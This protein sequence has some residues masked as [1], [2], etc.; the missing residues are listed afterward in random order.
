MPLAGWDWKEEVSCEA[1]VKPSFLQ[2]PKRNHC[3]QSIVWGLVVCS[4][5]VP[6]WCRPGAALVPPWCRPSQAVV[7]RARAGLGV[8]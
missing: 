1:R 8:Y 2:D 7:S 3:T 4:R 6:P 5:L